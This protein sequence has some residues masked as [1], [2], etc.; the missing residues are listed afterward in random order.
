[1]CYRKDPSSPRR[2][3][4]P[5]IFAR[6][7]NL[8]VESVSAKFSSLGEVQATKKVFAFPPRE[9]LDGQGEDS[10]KGEIA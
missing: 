9:S 4:I 2:I 10:R 6:W 8:S 5:T 3:R 1:M 7:A